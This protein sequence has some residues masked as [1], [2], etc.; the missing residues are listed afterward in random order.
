MAKAVLQHLVLSSGPLSNSPLEANA[1]LK[2]DPLLTRPDI[3]FHFV[4][5]GISEDYSMDIYDINTF[6]KQDGFGIL[7]I[8]IRPESRGYIGLKSSKPKDPPL[9]QPN[10]L[11]DPKDKE[12]LITA[13]KRA[14]EVI[15][16][17]S[18]SG[19]SVNG[20]SF[21]QEPLNDETL[22]EHIK[23]TAETLYHPV[24]TCKMGK[25]N[26][27]VVDDELRVYGVKSL[28]VIDASIMPTIISGNTNAAC[29]MIGEKGADLIKLSS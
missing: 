20:M 19:Y 24:G 10:L 25:D 27:A 16:T 21:P 22:W 23:K 4:P 14:I 7:A 26:M 8:L 17:K 28:R 15:S 13:L 1:F 29:I 5:L 12:V 3:Q 11:S 9:I 18:L 6:P 2:S